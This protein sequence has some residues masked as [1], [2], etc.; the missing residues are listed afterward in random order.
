MYF[1]KVPVKENQRKINITFIITN[2]T[3]RPF[4]FFDVIEYHSE[5]GRTFDITKQKYII[6]NE[7][8][9]NNQLEFSFYHL[10]WVGYDDINYIDVVVRPKKK[11]ANLNIKIDVDY[12]YDLNYRIFE[13]EKY[14]TQ[15]KNLKSNFNYYLHFKLMYLE[16]ANITLSMNKMSSQPFNSVS[17]SY[18]EN[19]NNAFPKDYS[20]QIVSFGEVNNKFVSNLTIHNNYSSEYINYITLNFTP[21]YDIDY[22][23]ILLEIGGT[24][25][26]QYYII[27]LN[28]SHSELD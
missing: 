18:Y 10:I 12:C 15:L 9:K 22:I 8:P 26:D 28:D 11:I 27:D 3:I 23:D 25:T 21:T 24:P 2:T 7:S 1:F 5:K 14:S 16:Y 4:D 13:D 6:R 20:N 17:I 19:E